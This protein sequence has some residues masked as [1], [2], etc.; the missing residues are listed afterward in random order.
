MSEKM[1]DKDKASLFLDILENT[2]T[3]GEW[4]ELQFREIKSYFFQHPV[5]KTLLPSWLTS[6]FTLNHFWGFIKCKFKTYQERR[7]FLAKELTPLITSCDDHVGALNSQSN[8]LKDFSSIGVQESWSKMLLRVEVDPDGA[9]TLART[10]VESVLKHISDELEISY[11][12]TDSLTSIYKSV[13]KRLKLSPDDHDEQIFKNIL[14]GCSSIVNGLGEMRNIYGDAHGKGR[15][16][17]KPSSRHA[18][19]AVNASAT[20]CLFLVETHNYRKH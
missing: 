17:R 12:S 8:L 20:L 10:T 1:K 5:Y 15:A 4:D 19:L 18:R 14:G 7:A 16:Q 13:T 9:I 6:T 2:A 3:G 11:T